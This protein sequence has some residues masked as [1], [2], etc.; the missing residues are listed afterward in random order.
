MTDSTSTPDR[1]RHPLSFDPAGSGQAART[2][3]GAAVLVRGALGAG[4]VLARTLPPHRQRALEAQW[5][6]LV[7][8]ALQV[9]LRVS[10]AEHFH[11]G[12]PHLVMPLHESFVDIPVL[13]GLGSP[14]RFVVRDELLGFPV[15]GRYLTASAQIPVPEAPRPSDLRRI[16]ESARSVIADGESVVVFPQGSV[17]GVESAFQRGS[18]WLARSLDVPILPIVIAGTHRIWG[19]PFSTSIHYGQAVEVRVLEP[20]PASEASDGTMRA[21][22][23]RMKAL[24]LDAAAPVRRYVPERDGWWDGYR[25]EV[26]PDFPGLAR[27][28]AAH[29]ESVRTDEADDG[30]SGGP[31]GRRPEA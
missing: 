16:R 19:F 20:I 25:F 18:A 30:A 3:I 10:G 4:S 6:R 8:R 24:A 23:R 29:R 9:D 7:T 14:M 15:M 28:V 26:D 21:I 1:D 5:G 31:V 17:L 2:R 22:E 27:A 11:P 12:R 13:L